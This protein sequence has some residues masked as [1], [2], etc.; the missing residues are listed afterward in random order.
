MFHL[1]AEIE[2]FQENLISAISLVKSLNWEEPATED[3][4]TEEK[5]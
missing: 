1:I 3:E 5:K 2:Y 4:K